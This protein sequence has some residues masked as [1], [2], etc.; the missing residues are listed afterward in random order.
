MNEISIYSLAARAFATIG[1]I[2]VGSYLYAENYRISGN[3]YNEDGL[4]LN[5]ALFTLI[6]DES[7]PDRTKQ[8]VAQSDGSFILSDVPDGQYYMEVSCEGYRNTIG[9]CFVTENREGLMFNLQADPEARAKLLEEVEVTAQALQTYVDRDEM[10]LSAY[11]RQYGVNALDAIS[12]LPRFIPSINGTALLNSQMQNVNILIDGRKASVDQLRNLDGKDIAKVVY[13]QDAPAKYRGLYGGAVV[14]VLLKKPKL[15]RVTAKVDTQTAV[16][17][18]HTSDGAGLAVFSP[19]GLLNANYNFSYRNITGVSSNEIYDYGDLVNSYDMT[20]ARYETKRNRGSVSYQYEKGKNLLYAN[21]LINTADAHNRQSLDLTES[22]VDFSTGGTRDDRS[23]VYTD[24]YSL[25]L[26]YSRDLE[27]GRELMLDVV[28]TISKNRCRSNQVQTTGVESAFDDFQSL[29]VT[30]A[31]VKSIIANASYTFPLWE[32][33]ASVSLLNNYRHVDQNYFNSLFSDS[34]SLNI[35]MANIAM[36]SAGY[37]RNFGPLG[38]SLNI[39]LTDYL[40][41]GA[42]GTKHN[43]FYVSPRLNL[44]YPCS[45]NLNLKLIGWMENSLIGTGQQNTNRTL[46]DTRYFK[47]N[48]PYMKSA[49]RYNL[50]FMPDFNIPSARLMI[51]PNIHY[52][53]EKNAY[54]Q[55]IY[56]E[57]DTFIQRPTL[58]PHGNRVQYSLTASWMP[59]GSLQVRTWLLGNHQAFNTPDGLERFNSFQFRLL[60]SYAVKSLQFQAYLLSPE[61][62]VDGITRKRKGWEFYLSAY[63]QSSSFYAGLDLSSQGAKSSTVM[64]VPGFS[65]LDTMQYREMQCFITLSL[66]YNF[67][68]GKYKGGATRQ[69]R[70]NNKEMETGI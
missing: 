40:T 54:I 37:M 17:A 52:T 15:V 16:N 45:R 8:A 35:S 53:W 31:L 1:M 60:T 26:Y 6:G 63:W 12:S 3:I 28:G 59:I 13:Y 43:E 14:N 22:T 69:K 7:Q 32:G 67:S 21:F 29:S 10:Y 11:N 27:S 68:V 25:N 33:S 66:G 46:I 30:D 44:N 2:T 56:R 58:Q 34:P 62:S 41:H 24:S 49:S 38:L 19:A 39:D 9:Q 20:S 47:E 42:D 48:I 65:S 61:R 50:L 64:E 70:L 23:H 4:P 51:S 5:G 55:Y 18:A 57:G 36:L